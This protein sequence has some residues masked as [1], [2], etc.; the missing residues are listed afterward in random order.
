MDLRE[1]VKDMTTEYEMAV[2]VEKT[3]NRIQNKIEKKKATYKDARLF[4]EKSGRITGRILGKHIR[5]L[6]PEGQIQEED[7]RALVSPM[8]RLNYKQVTDITAMIQNML[9]ESAGLGL[10]AVVP[11]YDTDRE[12]GLIGELVRRSFEDEFS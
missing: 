6:F 1:T 5:E 12:E 7:A 9:N 4:A 3:I 8:L 10:K 11:E 2:R